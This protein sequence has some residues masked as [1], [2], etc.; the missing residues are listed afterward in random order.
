MKKLSK[1]IV[2]LVV[3]LAVTALFAIKTDAAT[4]E[5][6]TFNAQYY[7][8]EYPDVARAVNNDPT[9]AYGHYMNN[10]IKEGRSGI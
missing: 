4:M 10:G 5:E 7:L 1:I 6:I 2:A 9:A 8:H 3:V